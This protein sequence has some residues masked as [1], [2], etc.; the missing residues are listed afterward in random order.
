MSWFLVLKSRI[1][2]LPDILISTVK[3]NLIP[4]LLQRDL[5][6]EAK[7]CAIRSTPLKY[8]MGLSLDRGVLSH[9]HADA[10][11]FKSTAFLINA[12][13]HPLLHKRI[14]VAKQSII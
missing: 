6:G 4:L 12:S 10:M 8:P 11:S 5:Q 13:L 9:K 7:F 14:Q 3:S 1:P 2:T